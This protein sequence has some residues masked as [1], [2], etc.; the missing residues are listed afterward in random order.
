MNHTA[1][2]K[3][4][5]GGVRSF[6]EGFTGVIN[7]GFSEL[8]FYATRTKTPVFDFDL[9]ARSSTPAIPQTEPWRE[10]LFSY[11]D[12]H[13]WLPRIGVA[14]EHVVSFAVQVRFVLSSLR[15]HGSNGFFEDYLDFEARTTIIDDHQQTYSCVRRAATFFNDRNA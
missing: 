5:R 3:H 8:G 11:I 6:T 7:T 14:S 12:P 2:Y 4:L 13:S 10:W 9:L 1:K 15:T